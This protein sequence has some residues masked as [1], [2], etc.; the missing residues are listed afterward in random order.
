MHSI[1][2]FLSSLEANNN[3]ERFHEHKNEYQLAR[4][5]FLEIVSGVRDQLVKSDPSLAD[6]DIRKSM[7]RINR[8]ARFSKDKSP[9]KNN[10]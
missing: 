2:T 1:L 6:I 10:F 4:A 8:D 3:A 5:G 7:F 9:Y